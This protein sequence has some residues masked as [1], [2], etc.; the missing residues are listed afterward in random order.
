MFA[1]LLVAMDHSPR[2]EALF[3]KGLALAKL[4]Q[5]DLM[6]LHVLSSEEEGSPVPIPAGADN[7]YWS[8]GLDFNTEIWRQEWENYESEC[9]EKLRSL[10]QEAK[11]S[12]VNS[13]FRQILGNT[14]RVICE[15]AQSWGADLILI[16]NRGRSGL[17][18]MVLG[19]VSNYV[20]HHALC[21]VLTFKSL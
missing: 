21:D 13:E 15:F 16:G 17:K 11:K 9:V 7:M 3:Q 5:A 12:G 18:E 14:G 20:L 2:G 6:L 19:S 10:A 8:P 4:H 1:K